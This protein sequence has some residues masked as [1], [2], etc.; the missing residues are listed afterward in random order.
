ME[1]IILKTRSYWLKFWKIRTSRFLEVLKVKNQDCPDKMRT[2]GKYVFHR[3][4]GHEN[5]VKI[6][7]EL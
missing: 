3:S 6:H 7:Q 1:N 5:K 4:L 2:V